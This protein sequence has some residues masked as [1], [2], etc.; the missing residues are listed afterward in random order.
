MDTYG[1]LARQHSDGRLA[2]ALRG[3]DGLVEW[4]EDGQF[5]AIA[6]SPAAKPS[7][8]PP[9]ARVEQGFWDIF[10][11]MSLRGL[12]GLSVNG[13]VVD[14]ILPLLGVQ[15]AAITVVGHSLGSA[16]GTY[17]AMELALRAPRGSV[18]ACLFA[19]PRTGNRTFVQAFDQTVAEYRLFNYLLDMVPRIPF[20]P[21]YEPLPRRTVIQPST[22]EANIR[23]NLACNHHVICYCAMLDYEGTMAMVRSPP[24]GEEGS[25]MCVLGAETG[26]PSLAKTFASSIAGFVPV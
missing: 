18:Q 24:A 20:G 25:A 26:S 15:D 16:L 14:G 6:Y 4:L 3:T 1:Y 13:T 23:M 8:G 2:A 19:S 22:A 7:F 10:S 17:L 12:D 9:E 21:D 5:A 11:S